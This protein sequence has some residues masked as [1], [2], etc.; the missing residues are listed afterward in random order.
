MIVRYY[1]GFRDDTGVEAESISGPQDVE[2]LLHMIALRHQEP[3]SGHILSD[4]G[5]NVRDDLF[6]LVNCRH[7]RQ[8]QGLKTP[9]SDSDIVAII[10]IVEAG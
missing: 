6:I 7:L 4:D 8:L 2:A 10:P 9:L 5:R 1:A 3:L